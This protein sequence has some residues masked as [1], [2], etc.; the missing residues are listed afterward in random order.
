MGKDP[1]ARAS[2]NTSG[3]ASATTEGKIETSQQGQIL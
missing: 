3:P 2:R 1:E